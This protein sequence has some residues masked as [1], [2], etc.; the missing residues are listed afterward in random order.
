[1]TMRDEKMKTTLYA[2]KLKARLKELQDQRKKNLKKFE[3]DVRTWRVALSSWIRNMAGG[4][5]DNIKTAELRDKYR[6]SD[7][8]GFNTVRFFDGAPVPPKYPD[9]KLIRDIQRKIQY[10]AVTYFKDVYVSEEE[11]GRFFSGADDD[12]D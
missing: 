2:H 11:V 4:R 3:A 5:V 7:T 12:E 10:L 1:M 9:D 8:P 6:R